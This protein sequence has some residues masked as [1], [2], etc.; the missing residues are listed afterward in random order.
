MLVIYYF[1]PSDI[2]PDVNYRF[3]CPSFKSDVSTTLRR[4]YKYYSAFSLERC[5]YF[6][7]S[8]LASSSEEV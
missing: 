8:S 5:T 2:K 3:T 6:E 1:A 7:S 4:R